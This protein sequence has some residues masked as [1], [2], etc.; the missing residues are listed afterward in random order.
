M[1][2]FALFAIIVDTVTAKCNDIEMIVLHDE[3]QHPAFFYPTV[4]NANVIFS[5]RS[6]VSDCGLPA[7]ESDA[8]MRAYTGVATTTMDA[9]IP[10]H[11]KLQKQVCITVEG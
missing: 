7:M 3:L 9:P 11:G 8:S 2:R 4:E 10:K 6:G 1:A 5:Y